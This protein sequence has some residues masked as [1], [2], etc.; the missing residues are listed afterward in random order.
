MKKFLFYTNL[1]LILVT[2]ICYIVNDG[3][4][5]MAEVYLGM[6]QL[7]A[8]VVLTIY[9]IF[10]KDKIIAKH[11][12]IYW[13]LIVFFIFGFIAASNSSNNIAITLVFIYPMFIALYLT[14]IT[15]LFS[16]TKP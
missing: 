4:G 6:F 12:S 7:V 16:K 11:L 5:K 13:L 14:Y 1:L 3:T 8:A 10:Y 15:Y 2:A 9:T